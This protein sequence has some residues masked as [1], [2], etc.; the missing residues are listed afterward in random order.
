MATVSGPDEVAVPLAGLEAGCFAAADGAVS[1]RL[2]AV[3]EDE[4]IGRGTACFWEVG[5]PDGFWTT[6]I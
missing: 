1:L 4:S 3:E 5:C 2:G 6:I